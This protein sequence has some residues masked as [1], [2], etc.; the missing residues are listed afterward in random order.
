MAIGG[1]SKSRN[2]LAR[3]RLQKRNSVRRVLLETLEARQLLAVGPQLIGIQPD[4]GELLSPGDVLN[5]S[6]RELV[7]RFSDNGGIDESSLGGIRVI[8]SGADG[9][10]DRASIATDFGTNG[11]T[12]VEFYA[13]EAGQAG[14]GI[15]LKFTSVS[16]NN[17]RAPVVRV[18]GRTINIELNSN[19][20]LE[21]RVEDILQAFNPANV[22]P[23]TNLVYALRLRGSQTIGVGRT[24]DTTRSLFLSGANS[25]K[26]STNFGLSNAFEVRFVARETGSAGMGIRINF[27]TSDPGGE[28]APVISVTGKT[29]NVLLN[30]NPRFTTTARQL[31]DAINASP[32]FDLIEAQLVSGSGA[33]RIGAASTAFSPVILSGVSDIE[34]VPGYIGMGD[35]GREV[36]LRF[37]EPLPDDKY[38]IEILGTGVRTLL[39]VEGE[40]FN[41]GVSRSI[42]FELN[43]GV[44]I[45]SVV[46][47]P[48]TRNPTTG[49]LSWTRTADIDVYF[50][51]DKLIDVTKIASVNGLTLAQLT[52]Q[53][54]GVLFL[55]NSDTIVF[56][57]GSTAGVLNPQFYQLINSNGTLTTAD[58]APAVFP[59]LVQYYP[60][61]DR[62]T[63]RFQRS[64][65][66]YASGVGRELRLRVGTTETPPMAPVIVDAMATEPG[67]S[68]ADAFDLSTTWTPA[69]GT[70]Q[71]VLVNSR[72]E[73]STPFVLD[74]PGG[75]DEPGNRR[76]RMQDNLR[77]GADTVDGITTF[78]YNFQGQLGTYLN[79]ITEQQKIR[80]RE[81]FS[82][83]ERYLGVRFV[84]S[85]NQGMTIAVGDLRAVI[86]FPDIPGGTTPGATE[87]NQPGFT[88]YEAGTLASGQLATVLDSQDFSS[89]LVNEFGGTFT[90]AAMQAIGKL[91][92]LGDADEL[93][94][95]TIQSF[96]S[97]FAPGVGTEMVFPGDGDIV[98]GQFLYR[99]DSKD[100]DLYQ[101]SLPVAG[102]ISIET[103]AERM[104]SA[105]LLDTQLRLFQETP[106]GWEEI[107][108][109]DDYF[110][111]DSF[112]EL[113]LA[114]GNYIVG[115]S[116]SG[117]ASYDA[118]IADGGLGGLSQGNYQLRMDFTPPAPSVMRD[119][120]TE[121]GTAIDGDG[122]GIPGGVFDFWFRPSTTA[123]NAN[124]TTQTKFVD[125][126][127]TAT[128]ANGLISSP[129]KTIAAAIQAAAA[130][131]VIRVLGN[132]GADRNFAT[133]ADNLAYEIGFNSLGNALPD[134]ATLD[135]PKDVTLMIDAGAILKLRRARIGVGSS[136]VSVDRSGSALLVLGTPTLQTADGRVLTDAAGNPVLGSV[137][138]TSLNDTSLGRTITPAGALGAGDWGGLDFRNRID[139][140]NNRNRLEGAG[141]FLNWVSNADI[142]F[143]G[144]Q[145]VVDGSSQVVTP[146]QMVDSRPTIVHNMIT[147]S[148][149]AAMSATPDSFLESNFHS[150]LEQGTAAAFS[151]DYDRVGPDI[152]GNRVL[153]NTI[154]GL[155]V[156]VTTRPGT[157]LEKLTTQGRFDDTSIVHYLPENLEIQG[158]PGGA[159]QQSVGGTSTMVSRLDARLVIDPGT[160]IKS[161]GSRIDVAFG[162]QLIAEGTD[163]SPVV[164]TALNDIRY[165]AG[166]TFDTANRVGQ[167]GTEAEPGDW[168]GVYVGH[169]SSA[170]FDFAVIS[171]GGGTTR[172]GG[173]FAN[174]NAL[175]VHQAD[176]RLTHSR[177]EL[178]A[179][180]A[181]LAAASER[182]GRGT[183]EPATVFVRGAQPIIV[184]NIIR[185]NEGAALSFNVSALN[186]VYVED[187]GRSRGELGKSIAWIGNQGP[188][189]RD[190]RMDSNGINGL[191]VRGG[192]L[193]TEGVWDDTDI[194]HVVLDEV[195][196][197]DFHA[198]GG[199]RLKSSP[200]QSLVVKFESRTDLAGLTASGQALD[201]S[202][203]IGGSIQ[204]LGQ[205]GAPVI[206]TSLNDST[207]GAG[208]TVSGEAQLSTVETES[209]RLLPTGPEFDNGTLI[210]N[211]VAPGIPGQF[212]FDV[213]PAGSAVF[214]GRGGIS[215]QGNTQLLVNEDV[216][217]DFLNFIDVG[218]NGNAIDLALSNIT[219]APTLIAPDLVV[220]EGNFP[221]PNGL[222][223]WRIES[224]MDDGIAQFFNTIILE[225]TAPLGNLQVINYLDEDIRGVTDDILYVTG[226]P[227]QEDFRAFILDG[228][229]RVGFSQGGIYIESAGLLE[230]ATY[231]GWAADSFRNLLNNIENAGTTY[232]LPGNINTNNLPPFNDPEFGNIF[233]PA[234]ITSAFAWRVDPNA[235]SARVTSFLELVPRNPFNAATSGDWRGVLLDTF[236]N[237]RNVQLVVENESVRAPHANDTPS[238][239][240]YLGGLAPTET[241]G[242]ENRRLGYQ[243]Q[244]AIHSPTDRDVYSFE[245]QAGT[246]VWFD[247]DRTSHSLDSV[248][249]LIDANG[250]VLAAS[251]NSLAEEADPSLL[252]RVA[253]IPVESVN[254]LRL[255]VPEL[256]FESAAGAPKDLYSTNPRDAGF[257]VSLPGAAGT[258][259]LYHLR[260][261]SAGGTQGHYQLQVRLSEV[262]EVPGSSINYVD[263]RFAQSGI[264]LV[265][266]PL[267]SPL[268]GENSENATANDT[269]GNAQVLGNLLQTNRQAL[270]VAGNLD[271]TTDVDW[272]SFTIDYQRIRPTSIR[273]YF[274]TVFDVDYADGLGR[275]DITFYVFDGNQNL[276]LSSHSSNVV[277][278]QA[279]PIGGADNADLTRGSAGT[280]D[281]YI[282]SY[283]LPA[284]QYFI[285][286]TNSSRMPQVMTQFTDPASGSPLVR[287]QPIEG[288]QLIAEEHVDFNGGS[289]AAG[290]VVPDLFTPNAEVTWNLGDIVLY[291]SRD[292]GAQT[293]LHMVNPFTGQVSVSFDNPQGFDV[294][295][296]AFRPNGQLRAFDRAVLPPLVGDLDAQIDYI[297]ID[298]GTGGFTAIGASGLQTFHRELSNATPPVQSAVDSNDGVNPEAITFAML[299][300][301]ERGFFVGS[302]PTPFGVTP[303]YFGPPLPL[304]NVGTGRPGPSFFSNVLYEF[305][306]VTG[307]AL[308][309]IRADLQ[310][311]EGAGTSVIERAYIE[312]R[313]TTG[314]QPTQLFAR[315]VTTTQAGQ[316]VELIQDG[317]TFTLFNPAGPPFNWVFEFDLGAEARVNY[318]PAAG[319]GIRDGMSFTID[320]VDYE[321][322]TGSVVV[323]DA[324][325]GNQLSDGTTV[326]IQNASG[327]ERVFEFDSNNS[328]TS[329]TNIRVAFAATSSQA[330]LVNALVSAVNLTGFGVR[331]ESVAGSNRIS[332]VGASATAPVI[333]SG[334]G[335]SVDGVV[336]ATGVRIPLSE[337][338]TEAQFVAAIAAAMPNN[339]SVSFDS[340]RLNFAGA[341][342]AD[343]GDLETDGI[344]VDQNSTGASPFNTVIRVLANDTAETV[345]RRIVAA[346]NGLGFAGLSATS[347]GDRVQLFG[348]TVANPGS[349][350][351]GGVAPG[352]IVTGIAVIGNTLF[353]V[354]DEGGLYRVNNPQFAQ[355]VV[356]GYVATS[357]DLLGINFTGL[358]AGPAN[359]SLTGTNE[360]LLFGIDSD[361]VIYAF[362]TRGELQPVFANGATSV[363]TN[364]G[365]ANGLAL[366]TLQTNLWTTTNA[367]DPN[368]NTNRENDPGHGL[369]A[370]PNG[371]RLAV[372][373]GS[374][375]YFGNAT[376]VNYNFPGGAAGAM[377][378]V[379]FSLAGL[380]AADMPMLYFSYLSANENVDGFDP[381]D[382]FRVYASGE[383]GSWLL[384]ATNN[385]DP[386][387]RGELRLHPD[388][389][390]LFDQSAGVT[391]GW[392]QARV[393][394]DRLAGQENV[395]LRIEF[396]TGAGFGFGRQGGQGPEIRTIAGSR[397]FDGQALTIQGE[398]FE[399][400]MGPT[401]TLPGGSALSNGDSVTVDGV[402]YVFTDG[403]GPAIIAPDVPVTFNASHSPEQIAQALG[404]AISVTAAVVPVQSGF[405][406]GE[407]NDIISR[408]NQ[409]GTTGQ[410]VRITGLGEIGDRLSNPNQ[411][412]DLVRIDV[413]HGAQVTINVATTVLGSTLD[414]Y[415]RVFDSEG[416]QVAATASMGGGNSQLTLTDLEAG[417]YF[418]GVSGAGNQAYDAV[419][420]G[421]TAAG[422]TGT[423]EL[424]IEIRSAV[425]PFVSENRLQIQGANLVSV[426][427]ATP[428][429]MQGASGTNG[430]PVRVHVGMST[431]QVTAA[432]Q[433]A[434]A[435]YFAGGRTE[436][437]PTRGGDTINLTGLTVD[438]GGPFGVTTAFQG[439]QFTTFNS[440][441]RAQNNNFE[442][443]YVDDII[444][445]VAGRGE[446]VLGQPGG[447]TNFV[448]DPNATIQIFTGPYQFEVRGGAEYGMPNISGILLQETF[449][450]TERSGA[451]L[452]IR[453]NAASQLVAGTTFTVGDGPRVVTFE[454]D[455]V[456]DGVSVAPNHVALP[457]NAAMLDPLSGGFMAEPAE[458]IAARFRDLLNSPLVQLRINI[459]ANLLNN[460]RFGA[461][462]DTVVL[463]GNA[464]ALVPASVGERIVSTRNG[465]GNRVRPQ[466][467][468]VINAARISDSAGFGM[469]IDAA[470]RD[471]V[472]GAPS[473][474]APRNTITLNSDALTAGAVVMNSQF[475]GNAAGGISISGDE[476]LQANGVLWNGTRA[477]V[478]LV[479]NT[480][481]GGTIAGADT[482]FTA[483]GIG[484]QVAG[485]ATA[486]LLNN[487][488]VNSSV[489]ISVDASSSSTVIGGSAFYRN[490]NNVGG[491]ATV[492]QFPTLIPNTTQVFESLANRNLYPAA[493]S[494]VIDSSIDSLED[495]PSLVAVKG[496]LGIA[497]SPMLAPLRDI[498]GQLRVDDPNVETPAG[499]GERV[500]KDRGSQDRADFSGPSVKLIN[501]VDNDAAGLDG[502]AAETVVE[503]SGGTLRHFDINIL[504]GLEPSDP[505]RGVG[506]DASTVSSATVLLYGPKVGND[507]VRRQ[508]QPLVEGQDYRFGYDSTNGIIRLTPLAGIWEA[509][510][511]YTV[512]FLNVDAGAFVLP[513]TGQDGDRFSIVDSR[514]ITTTFE[515]DYGYLIQ[516]PSLVDVDLET[517]DGK[518]FIVDDGARR[519]VFELDRNG[520]VASG[521]RAVN[522]AAVTTAEALGRAVETAIRDAALNLTIT[523][524]S[525]GQ[526]QLQGAR[527][528]TF[529]PVDSGMTV[530]GEPGVQPAFGIQ[531][532]LRGGV[533]TGLTDGQTFTITR[534]TSTP[535]V[536]ELDTNGVTQPTNIPVRFLPSA[537][538]ATIGATLVAAINGAAL[539]LTASYAGG[540]LVVLG[541]DATTVLGLTNTVLTQAGVAGQAASVAIPISAAGTTDFAAVL[542][543]AIDSQNLPG[544][545]VTQFGN[546]LVVEGAN[547]VSGV[548]ALALSAIQDLAGN[549]LKANQLD[550]STTLTIFLGEGLDYGDAHRSSIGGVYQTTSTDGGPSHRVIDGL[551]LG[552]TV[553]VDAD[554]RL[555]DADLDDGVVFTTG[556][557]SGFTANAQVLVNNTTG[558]T[559]YVS[560]W[561]DFNGDG[562]FAP[563]E[564]FLNA[565]AIVNPTTAFSV[566]VPS[567]AMLGE[568]FMRVRLSTDPA[569]IASPITPTGAGPALDGEVEDHRITISGNPFTNPRVATDPNAAFDVSNDGFVSPIDILQIINW[570]NDPSKPRSLTLSAATG[571]PP[572]VDVNGDALVSPLDIL[573][574]INFLNARAAAGGEGEAEGEFAGGEAGLMSAFG[575]METTVLAS[576]WAAGLEMALVAN[577][578]SAVDSGWKQ[579]PH[580]LAILTSDERLEF[581]FA[582]ESVANHA[583]RADHFWADLAG[584]LDDDEPA[585]EADSLVDPLLGYWS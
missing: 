219:L 66:Q 31:V 223:S 322:D 103:F 486:T 176:V 35:S 161:Q 205:P 178:N 330:N 198:F 75:S 519:I 404:G 155:Q 254:P 222:V 150:P 392:R 5:V 76:I 328:L 273:E 357:S 387:P 413:Q 461:T 54:Q 62:V 234:D 380:S 236:S 106:N 184:D 204:L 240:Q 342:S 449:T 132:G 233:G 558:R 473:T 406:F 450:L 122:D 317:D 360:R 402:R 388:I 466:G 379:P 117:N 288:V 96:N 88:A 515:L 555:D 41:A 159:I 539:G 98:H 421:L 478:R 332:F 188:L 556:F 431:A 292:A 304:P 526:L 572:F 409:T 426:G 446:M 341:T 203:R 411:D 168:G 218:G 336:G 26:G 163:G 67:S 403:T 497:P 509:E 189:V 239:P 464:T 531:M 371:S 343:F 434:I 467:Q 496:P 13:Q 262:D 430:V 207:V 242:D 2:I 230:N 454:L 118:T 349:L 494:P 136:S 221:G 370:T 6:P 116:A 547:S 290:P 21:T 36:I 137:V 565:Q 564:R 576:D 29:V 414:S 378:S 281:P 237:D 569:S 55:Q 437:Y 208:F 459:A 530:T 584:G 390:P 215:A 119:A 164:F 385:T 352:G 27:S 359:T 48:V 339:I 381:R 314:A 91:L 38:R 369:P 428:I 533:P 408:A 335:L 246:E 465:G 272:Y 537:T 193:T 276:I 453:F 559:A 291:V 89:S 320:G 280:L 418:V 258:T 561:I 231:E 503:L 8:R 499:L 77:L 528:V 325:N 144:G 422:S 267:N 299:G 4:S 393:P 274:A 482:T 199:L 157:Q 309:T 474:G 518:T 523:E 574:I 71:S 145:V 489:G 389:Q 133:Q 183:N 382:A 514:E 93:E 10:F 245:A 573:H 462:S 570:Y 50:S 148:A 166:G 302:R 442:G 447:N 187:T 423:Y 444:I 410:S 171:Y 243:I 138:M 142:R 562:V 177:L 513:T 517:L 251:D 232:T 480:I 529:D 43:L 101:F 347:S 400:E 345:A 18:S 425:T 125:K 7:F 367:F 477:F 214:G 557:F 582:G 521:N 129:Y 72:I 61:A 104:S 165:G 458:V 285:A 364:L 552:P 194:V 476:Q 156:R 440:P 532:P 87:P 179:E 70:S 112:I 79:A 141:V 52:E 563:T 386:D 353:A 502:N 49:A 289:T 438:D 508:N 338:A 571:L 578:N 439:Q 283:E 504:D 395:K 416:R 265:G 235:N 229:E 505:S 37:A 85:A 206:L 534:G 500:F 47:Q 226:T 121:V 303:D 56:R 324:F 158:T 139:I 195:I 65:D 227:G 355:G 102:Q 220:S 123:L 45:L 60:N 114:A 146:I 469:T 567:G 57:D 64:L 542:K 363:R 319:F 135:V 293:N 264:Q 211:D 394:L 374:S 405:T 200:T 97:V 334:T 259:N 520:V 396:S 149:D 492:G 544:V 169:T 147:S 377:E 175:E 182:G 315:E 441:A 468:V 549:P 327:V 525:S 384:L 311:F 111:S 95:L 424:S 415:L 255:S 512:R 460:D 316:L 210:D 109:N 401:L 33:T 326:R 536:F 14:N 493:S 417:A 143:G 217:F 318:N 225:S 535:V 545:M 58:D 487:V 51:E 300:G 160:I 580:D 271:S 190:N 127:S 110:S 28:R 475:I 282:D 170:S 151:V 485:N 463:I 78:F 568:T 491:V 507:G 391:T 373:G 554:A 213:G 59:S 278:D 427:E 277:D 25:A 366:S 412:V 83:Y 312:T 506:V 256:Y 269:I 333:V 375:F 172:V 173:G 34:I 452:S 238:N 268:L 419:I 253:E 372:N 30:S 266:I 120:D 279:S 575:S 185:Q 20:V 527:G 294:E 346:V 543:S 154:N 298:T 196:V 445:G 257:R 115:V 53:R 451:G 3:K 297:D 152:R 247:I 443:I 340:G 511:V 80:V 16:R 174:F 383:D 252:F 420:P 24:V 365:G 32:A 306:E 124:G 551:S 361:G 186:S 73:N 307:A 287:L 192:N 15:E 331:A 516:I 107:A 295:D 134:G 566:L 498:N 22:T 456:N 581:S 399:L 130:G 202:D 560:L 94:Q 433:A 348:A 249:E 69:A 398:R 140:S 358:V 23:A 9:A 553:T 244:G 260:V 479:N 429:V 181:T 455:D 153:N 356:N 376:D 84:E 46:P 321:F 577:K 216:I 1:F 284:G 261:R 329:G 296:I 40:P 19:P 250:R 323:M 407:S 541:G 201:N 436:A 126:S 12:L 472:T 310:Q 248:L 490:T 308:G 197:P 305:D 344:F 63:L 86:P 128:L 209:N 579:H 100:I 68:F 90:R 501:P 457:F 546:R 286:V 131:D 313:N 275:P 362:N 583:S 524:V 212:A 481:V 368:D 44:Q 113:T 510:A 191:L 81:V 301:V 550:G 241:S 11:Q 92:G 484:I 397:L 162:G 105:S 471:P 74:F 270:S 538:A 39:N 470:P 495:R 435:D 337:A 548:G 448:A 522:V 351:T 483:G 17:N 585:D 350:Q 228:P 42:P 224:R 488:V 99:P 432:L 180:G 540:G 263:I 82:L 108:A 167:A 354:S